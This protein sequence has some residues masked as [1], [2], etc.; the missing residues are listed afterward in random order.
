MHWEGSSG[1]LYQAC[2]FVSVN[3]FALKIPNSMVGAA[4]Q[5]RYTGELSCPLYPHPAE[6]LDKG[7]EDTEKSSRRWKDKK[8]KCTILQ[9][10]K[11]QLHLAQASLL[12]LPIQKAHQRKEGVTDVLRSWKPKPPGHVLRRGSMRKDVVT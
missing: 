3:M 9:Q 8:Q 10:N 5:G 6:W 4:C 7:G 11:I 1:P 2:G 12:T